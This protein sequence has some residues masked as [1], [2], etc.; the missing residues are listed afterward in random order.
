MVDHKPLIGLL[1]KRE[2]GT[3]E[4]HRLEH[5]AKRLLGLTF[6]IEHVAGATNYGP[7]T[8]TRFPGPAAKPGTLGVVNHEA[9]EWSADVETQVLALAASRRTLD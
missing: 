9:Q 5:L 6:Q 8:L 2:L 3:I 4:N 7:N 1:T